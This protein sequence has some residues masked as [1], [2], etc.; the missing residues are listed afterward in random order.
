M[1]FSSEVPMRRFLTFGVLLLLAA[2]LTVTGCGDGKLRTQGRVV[3]GGQAF[4]ADSGNGEF[5]Q[6]TFIPVMP[7]GTKPRSYYWATVDQ[8]TGTFTAAGADLHG[9]PPGKYR[10]QVQLVK[11]KSDLWHNKLAG[12][13]SPF[14]FDIDSSVRDIVID[15]DGKVM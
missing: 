4:I 12:P 11:N 9:I 5:L 7:D 13:E 14:E 1:D 10:V 6:V 3:K 8:A 2:A 15:L